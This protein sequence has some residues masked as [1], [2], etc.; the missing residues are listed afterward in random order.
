M[1]AE[2]RFSSSG[3]KPSNLKP[4]AAA[5]PTSPPRRHLHPGA[6]QRSPGEQDS[7]MFQ[8]AAA[9]RPPALPD[10]LRLWALHALPGEMRDAG[11]GPS[12]LGCSHRTCSAISAATQRV[13]GRG[14]QAQRLSWAAPSNCAFAG[15]AERM[16]TRLRFR[17]PRSLG[18]LRPVPQAPREPPFKATW[19]PPPPAQGGLCSPFTPASSRD[20]PKPGKCPGF[21]A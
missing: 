20:Y 1:Q 18:Q 16:R 6:R 3:D 12:G 7:A 13:G 9:H 14:V 2:P 4:T 17:G 5:P 21:R 11:M 19:F 10:Q 8:R 15:P